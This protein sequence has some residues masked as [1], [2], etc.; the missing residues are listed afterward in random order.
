MRMDH[1]CPWINNCVGIHNHK[2][3]VLLVFYGAASA[4]VGVLTGAPWLMFCLSAIRRDDGYAMEPAISFGDARR[5][6]TPLPALRW[7][8]EDH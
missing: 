5:Q 6:Q 8:T 1:H 2:F 3:F 4:T 7:R